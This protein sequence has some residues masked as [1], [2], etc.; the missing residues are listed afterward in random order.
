MKLLLIAAALLLPLAAFAQAPQGVPHPATE[1]A[2]CTPSMGLNFVCGLDQPEDL[3]QIGTSK[4]V[5]ASGMG[6]HGGVFLLDTEAR[7]ARRFFTGVSKPDLKTYP[8]RAAPP[9]SFNTHGL[10]LRPA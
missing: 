4:W 1:S 6:E 5:I 9:Q 2:P 7:K 10:A 3:L 8:D